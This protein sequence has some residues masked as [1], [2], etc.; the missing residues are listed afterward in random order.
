MRLLK[1]QVTNYKSIDDSGIIDLNRVACLVG[2][3]ESG[4]TSLLEALAKLNPIG[5]S[6][7]LSLEDYPRRRLSKYKRK[8]HLTRPDTAISAW[9]CLDAR[10]LAHINE[11]FGQEFISPNEVKVT[12]KYDNTL[13]FEFQYNE[14]FYIHKLLSTLDVDSNIRDC[15]EQAQTLK[16]LLNEAKAITQ[17]TPE[18]KMFITKLEQ[19]IKEDL[20]EKLRKLVKLP[21]F[22]YFDEYSVLPGK[23]CLQDLK[24]K[25]RNNNGLTRESKTALALID[26]VGAEIED[27]LQSENYEELKANLEAASND[28]TDQV[29]EYWTQNKHLEVEFTLEPKLDNQRRL[30]D[31][32]LHVRIK[33]QRHRV[34]VS[35][36]KRSRGFIWFFSFLVAFSE[37][38]N[39]DHEVILLLDEPGL[40]LHAKAQ[41]DLLRFIDKEL[42]PNHQVLYTTHS[43]FMIDP[44][45]LDR[46]CIVEDREAEGTVVSNDIFKND[47]DTVFPLQAALGYTLAQ[48]LFLGPATLLVEGPSDLIYL[49][50][51]AEKL[52]STDR[53]SIDLNKWVIVPVGGADKISTFVSLLGANQLEVAVLIDITTADQPRINKLTKNKLLNKKNL[54]T[55]GQFVGKKNADIEDIFVP[56]KYL[57]LINQTYKKELTGQPI[58]ESDIAQGNPRIVKRLENHFKKE[59][60]GNSR[61]GH[62]RPSAVLLQNPALQDQLFDSTALDRFEEIFKQI[63]N[64]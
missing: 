8:R 20:S 7:E 54:F 51:A 52:S 63:N 33:N 49:K 34:T 61:F 14:V 55:V 56:E 27:F 17:P 35:F 26:L 36:D 9:F 45:Q 21:S 30:E 15:L 64:I 2:K 22:F 59:K 58:T 46:V 6:K 4:K 29:F 5:L 62:Y 39:H 19:K 42:A 40:N 18:L 11:E 32:I 57:E 44:K 16:D 24:G 1:F 28:I 37:Y 60:I 13:S 53:E 38:E 43:P 50:I 10:E 47:P 23:I 12:K 48:T 3:N 25:L 41:E 31:T